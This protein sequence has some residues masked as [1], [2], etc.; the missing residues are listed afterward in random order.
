MTAIDKSPWPSAFA[1]ARPRTVKAVEQIVTAA[2]PRFAAS[3]LSWILHDVQDPQSPDPVMMASHFAVMS[4]STA[5]PTG[6]WP[7]LRCFTTPAT[8]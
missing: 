3:T 5:S 4:C 2:S 1:C 7:G 6:T 8:P